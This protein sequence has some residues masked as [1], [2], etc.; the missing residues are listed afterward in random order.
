MIKMIELHTAAT[1][2]RVLTIAGSDSGG[3]AGIQADLKTAA[4]LGCHGSSAIT[5]ITAQNSTGVSGIY[6]TEPAGVVAQ[7][8][9][10][11]SDIGADAVKTGM[12]FSADIITAVAASLTRHG[13]S[14]L[15]VDPV[16]IAKGGA[17]LLQDDAVEALKSKL[18]PLATLVTPNLPEAEALTGIAPD[19]AEK[20]LEV[21][22]AIIE[23]GA[24]AVLLKG[25]HG[26]GEEL[27]DLF[28]DGEGKVKVFKSQRFDTRN[29]HGTGCTLAAATTAYLAKGETM[30]D[31]V[32]L[33]HSFVNRA[34]RY[35][36]SLGE[37]HGPTNP[38]VAALTGGE[39][40]VLE[41]LASAWEI[42]EE[43]N[44]YGL[45][46]EVQS[47]LAEALASAAGFTD[48][49]AFT[50]RIIKAGKRIRRVD[51][52]SFGASRHMAKILMASARA[53][54]PFR[55]VMNIRYGADV[56]EACARLGL[57][58]EGFDRNDEPP[59]VKAAEGS[60]LEWGTAMV[61]ES[62]GYAPD[63]IFDEGDVGKEPMI[64]IFG[65]D[66]IDVA[67]RVVALWRILEE[68]KN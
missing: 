51:G 55:A 14:T 8:D 19:T 67:N 63:A 40:G 60:T 26:E 44:P 3:G 36:Y 41:R 64:R 49:A 21:C 17:K 42:L 45:I 1:P 39:R 5:A 10:V 54:S 6:P 43:A 50:G 48:V 13:V 20:R 33:G 68:K 27:E 11:L 30:A 9:A 59:E 24:G 22:R 25:G 38:Y 18:L 53:A 34:I 28:M 58:V 2:P 15:V 46:P 29:T 52:P 4:V 31:A 47:N 16:M 62:K 12:L 23:L 66:A 7:I 37:G 65:M 57:S 32:A 35:G 61:L 56:L